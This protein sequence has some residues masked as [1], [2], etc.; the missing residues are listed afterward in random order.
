MNIIK[1]ERYFDLISHNEKRNTQK[2]LFESFISEKEMKRYKNRFIESNNLYESE[3]QINEDD[4]DNH[5]VIDEIRND[6][7]IINNTKEF[8]SSLN[9]SD[10]GEFLT[11]YTDKEFNDMTTYK[12][13]NYNAGFA[14]KKDGDIVSVHNNSGIKGIGKELLKSAI[15]FGGKK[16]DHFDGFLTGFYK[17][18]GFN[19]V[20][21]DE[22]ND[23]YAPSDWKY[24]EVDIFNPQTSIYADEIKKYNNTLPTHLKHKIQL[25]KDGKPDIIYREL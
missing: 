17:S 13:K 9:K 19:I 8:M 25:Y 7:Y 16:L 11:S 18:L 6:N 3:F 5:S 12:L 10:K 1:L 20:G 2:K 4:I 22:W 15:K 21:S 23:D 14:I 24:D